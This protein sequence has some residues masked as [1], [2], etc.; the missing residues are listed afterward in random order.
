MG[1]ELSVHKFCEGM[2]HSNNHALF[3]RK[4]MPTSK[5]S[6]TYYVVTRERGE[7]WDAR[8]SMLQQ[9]KWDEHAVFI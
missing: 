3:F 9:E 4:E 6:V 8:L 1:L 2:R 5:R 7:N